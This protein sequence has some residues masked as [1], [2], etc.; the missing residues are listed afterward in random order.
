MKLSCD[1]LARHLNATVA[2][3]GSVEV[4]HVAPLHRAS[5]GAISFVSDKRHLSQLQ[6]CMATAVILSEDL[7]A[8]FEGVSVI[9]TNPYLDYAK[10]ATILHPPEILAPGI[11][12]S[13][14][15]SDDA[16][17]GFGA[18]IGAGVSIDQGASIGDHSIVEPGCRIGKNVRIGS[19]THLHA[20]VV[21]EVGCTIGDHCLLQAGTVIG[22]DGFGYAR[23]S[24]RWFHIPQIG[25]VII[26]DYV[27]IGANTTID[28]GALDDTVIENGVILDNQIQVA[29]NVVIGENTAVAG[30]VGIAGSAKI[31]KRCTIGGATTILGH[32]EIVDDVHI[33]AMS[34]VSSSILK[35]GNYTSAT[36]VD[37]AALW[38]KNFA[39]FRKLDTMAR[40]VNRLDRLMCPDKDENS[41]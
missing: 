8:H 37:E 3:D 10:A 5:H 36:P 22:S 7:K 19:N 24:D 32:L 15:V 34:L 29:H 30:C 31:G 20:N 16:T 21:I 9:S 39:R 40:T 23:D 25:S 35:A 17:I 6:Q 38:R 4:D 28:R 11:H 2:G 41:Q 26:G 18:H 1:E 14:F 27:E 13:A 12:Q 33:N